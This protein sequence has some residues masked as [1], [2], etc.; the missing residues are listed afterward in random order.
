MRRLIDT[1][2]ITRQVAIIDPA[3]VNNSL[4]ALIEITLD[5]QTEEYVERF[6]AVMA[7]ED[8]ILQ[9]YRVSP[10]T[11]FLVLAQVPAMPAYHAMARMVLPSQNNVRH[12]PTFFSIHRHTLH[13]RMPLPAGTPRPPTNGPPNCT[14]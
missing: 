11:D 7:A 9:C 4:T 6:E 8:A 13:T 5:I 10:G 1:G 12:A 2:V 14:E 3:K